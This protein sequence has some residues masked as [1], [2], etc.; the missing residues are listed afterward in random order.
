MLAAKACPVSWV[1]NPVATP[2]ATGTLTPGAGAGRGV[3]GQGERE[4]VQ[5]WE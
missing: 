4:M 1:L 5:A 2:D 3:T